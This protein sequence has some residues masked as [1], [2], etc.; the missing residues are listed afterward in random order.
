MR[1]FVAGAT[2]A[3]GR[4][5]IPKLVAGGH[6]VSG[7]TRKK[8]NSA[9]IR[10]LGAEPFVADGL[11]REA[12]CV[13]VTQAAPDVIVHEMTDLAGASDL[14]H[15]DRTF[16]VSN[17]LRTEGT[18]NLLTAA[19]A[20]GVARLIAQ[21][22]CGW[23]FARTGA[24]VKSE[25]DALDPSP[26]RQLLRTLEAIRY[27][28]AAV[29]GAGR[30]AGIV[31]RYGTFYGPGTGLFDHGFAEQIRRRRVP[32]IGDGGGWWSF[33][34]IDDAAAATVLAIERGKPGE[35]YNIADDDPAP[36]KDWLPAL[37]AMLGA[38][39][40]LHLPAWLA[41]VVAGQHLVTMMT[42]TR[43]ASNAK[44]RR[45]LGWE[46]AHHSWRDGF[47]EIVGLEHRQ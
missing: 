11:D 19:R 10:T 8:E 31:L 12:V 6:S 14:R 46:P 47:A 42:E 30:P 35:I 39:P 29:T 5:L 27:L 34:H 43:A 38:K 4:S 7:L 20:S 16:A 13:V 36:V 18:D 32:L 9:F 40:P 15:F 21:S 3:I 22:F 24:T 1:I 41:R 45:C 37:A 26:P 25:A 17:R 23:P 2:G 44:A 33:V 28:E